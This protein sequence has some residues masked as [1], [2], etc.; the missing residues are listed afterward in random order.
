[1][2]LHGESEPG[3]GPPADGQVPRERMSNR[4]RILDWQRAPCRPA[5]VLT[6]PSGPCLGQEEHFERALHLLGL[7]L[8]TGQARRELSEPE[9]HDAKDTLAALDL[10]LAHRGKPR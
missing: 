9:R 2:V 8:K 5:T 7:S 1:M 3:H 4:T 10:S 6:R